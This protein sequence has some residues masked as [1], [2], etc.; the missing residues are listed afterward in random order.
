MQVCTRCGA[1]LQL[2]GNGAPICTSCSV[3]EIL[4]QEVLQTTAKKAEAFRK[5]E[6]IM[7]QVP[8]GLPHS[9]GVQRI[10]NASNE[11]SI[12]RKEMARAYERLRNY[13]DRGIVP[14]DLQA[15]PLK[16]AAAGAG[17]DVKAAAVPSTIFLKLHKPK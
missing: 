8:S 7:L 11:L 13:L 17:A 4:T 6:A 15:T 1:E 16:S 12:T 5:F 3:R 10:K 9:D 2:C 14:A